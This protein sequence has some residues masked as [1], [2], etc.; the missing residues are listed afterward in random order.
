MRENEL[1]V[2][3]LPQVT[4]GEDAAE[5]ELKYVAA[6]VL[7][8]EFGDHD[9]TK[10]EVVRHTSEVADA[11]IE[12]MLGNLRQQRGSW[13]K[14]GRGAKAGDLVNVETHSVI[15]GARMPA[16]GVENTSTVLGSAAMYPEVE[17]ALVGMQPG[18]AKTLDVTL[19]A[20]WH[21]VQFAGKT[22][23]STFMLGEVF[24]LSLIH[25]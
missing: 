13:N 20:D 17:T 8:S 4:P 15:D 3:G 10:L 25:I 9:M 21:A 6:V 5:G 7:V 18:E 19:P 12:R 16:E 1:L 2:D 23:T 22:V 24:E 11:D 14:V